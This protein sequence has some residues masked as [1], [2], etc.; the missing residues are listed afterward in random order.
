MKNFAILDIAQTPIPGG[1]SIVLTTNNPCH[2]TCYWTDKKPLRHYT[3]RTLRGLTVPWGS[4]YCFVAWHAVEQ[5]EP[6]DTL[7]HTFDLNEWYYCQTRWFTFRGTVAGSE[8]PSVGPIFEKHKLLLAE[9]TETQTLQNG[10]YYLAQSGIWKRG[11]GQKLTIPNRTVSKL[12]FLLKQRGTAPGTITYFIRRLDKSILASKLLGTAGD[13]SPSPTW[14]EVIFDSPIVI[15]EEVMI[16][17]EGTLA[18]QVLN[19]IHIAR[20]SGGSVKANENSVSWQIDD[21][22]HDAPN[23]DCAYIYTYLLP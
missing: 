6:G 23:E 12:S 16:T 7:L 17:C 8:S 20:Q 4:Y 3:T 10:F 13:I 19:S 22:W 1:I 18:T 15:N 14:Y 2:L 11:Y 5:N 9:R 21:D